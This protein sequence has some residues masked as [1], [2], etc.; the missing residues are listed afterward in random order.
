M[1]KVLFLA[2]AFVAGGCVEAP[3]PYITPDA[4]QDAGGVDAGGVDAGDAGGVDAGDAGDS[5]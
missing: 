3:P 2:L 1:S 5:E 4:S